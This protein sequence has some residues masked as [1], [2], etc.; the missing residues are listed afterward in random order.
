MTKT[1]LK[2][3]IVFLGMILII[4]TF[5]VVISANKYNKLEKKYLELSARVSELERVTK[6]TKVTKVTSL[7]EEPGDNEIVI[8]NTNIFTEGGEHE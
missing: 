2:E 3:T 1:E 5:A 8:S 7:P 6:V 4:L